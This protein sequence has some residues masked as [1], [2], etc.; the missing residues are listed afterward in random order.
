MI[1]S[2]QIVIESSFV[3]LG[4]IVLGADGHFVTTEPVRN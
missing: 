2:I 1:V 4:H 3:E